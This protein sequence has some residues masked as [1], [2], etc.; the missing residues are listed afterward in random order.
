MRGRGSGGA[1]VPRGVGMAATAGRYVAWAFAALTALAV[2]SS[3]S[4]TSGAPAGV[5]LRIAIAEGHGRPYELPTA[6]ELRINTGGWQ[7]VDLPHLEPLAPGRTHRLSLRVPGYRDPDAVDLPVVTGQVHEITI[8]LVPRPVPV[9][10][11]CNTPGAVIYEGSRVVGHPGEPILLPAFCTHHLVVRADR[12]QDGTVT[13]DHPDPL[14]PPADYPVTLAPLRGDLRVVAHY[15]GLLR[16]DASARISLDGELV[17]V[18]RLPHVLG[19]LTQEVVTVGLDVTGFKPVQPRT[20]RVVPGAILDVEFDV[21]YL[22]AFLQF[23]VLPTNAVIMLGGWRATSNIVRVIPDLLYTVR[24]EAPGH[25]PATVVLSARPRETHPVY[26]EL[27]PCTYFQFE[28]TPPEAVVYMDGRRIPDRM[29]EITP[30]QEYVVEVRAPHYKP[31]TLRATAER[32]ETRILRADL[33]RRRL[34]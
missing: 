19:G 2:P 27:D 28:L 16:R 17:H 32:G 22:D 14:R 7:A 25:R 11:R 1:T 29:V 18:A 12:H 10:V 9:T 33:N 20:V 31:V 30:G 5:R 24:V 15:P 6:G 23:E 13:V 21:E 34:D 4:S 26:L 8:P 3:G